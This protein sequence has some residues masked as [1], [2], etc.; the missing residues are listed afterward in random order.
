[1]SIFLRQIYYFI[2]IIWSLAKERSKQIKGSI[3]PRASKWHKQ[4]IS[5]HIFPHKSNNH[6]ISAVSHPMQPW[7]LPWGQL[8]TLNSTKYFY[9]KPSIRIIKQTQQFLRWLHIC[10][11]PSPTSSCCLHHGYRNGH[12]LTIASRAPFNSLPGGNWTLIQSH[13]KT[14]AAKNGKNPP[15]SQIILSFMFW[16]ICV[17]KKAINKLTSLPLELIGPC[18]SVHGGN[19]P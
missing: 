14:M 9:A 2:L 3:T 5:H 1:M 17:F 6:G 13:W 19:Y 10:L 7:T 16:Q 11:I 15:T 18:I 4:K 8:M 12:A